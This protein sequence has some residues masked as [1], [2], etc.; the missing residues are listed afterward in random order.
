M[1]DSEGPAH[2]NEPGLRESQFISSLL[3]LGL[4]WFFGAGGLELRL[5][6]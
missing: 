1:K 5:L 2:C 4:P 3:S 6:I